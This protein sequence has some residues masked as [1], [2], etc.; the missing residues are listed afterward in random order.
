MTE[1]V[2]IRKG[3]KRKM[4]RS[5]KAFDN[6]LYEV[7]DPAKLKVLTHLGVGW[8]VN[9]DKYGVDLTNGTRYVEVEVKQHWRTGAS[10]FPFPN[11]NLPER[12]GKYLVHGE[13]LSF[14]ILSADL[15]HAMVIPATAVSS[16]SLEIVPNKYVKYGERFYKIDTEHCEVICLARS[17][18]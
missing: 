7:N 15:T 3:T 14:W 6:T 5:K 18:G 9:P 1:P 4:Q 11:V 2:V 13:N 16:S 17:E 10:K 8:Y 12:K